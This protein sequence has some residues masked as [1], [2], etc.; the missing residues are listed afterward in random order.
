MRGGSN[1]ERIGGTIP[2]TRWCV[3]VGGAPNP[4]CRR[5]PKSMVAAAHLGRFFTRWVFPERLTQSR[6]RSHLNLS[7]ASISISLLPPP[8]PSLH[9][10]LDCFQNIFFLSRLLFGFLRTAG[11]PAL[12][13]VFISK[14]DFL[15]FAPLNLPLAPFGLRPDWILT[16]SEEAPLINTPHKRKPG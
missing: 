5:R 12:T 1:T 10:L 13:L 6:L 8:W 14:E 9:Q 3:K 2:P 16:R 4:P 7:V 11:S 15:R